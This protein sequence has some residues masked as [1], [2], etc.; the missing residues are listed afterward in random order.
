MPADSANVATDIRCDSRPIRASPLPIA[1]IA[2]TSGS[3]VAPSRPEDQNRMI[4]AARKPISSGGTPP[5]AAARIGEG[6]DR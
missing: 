1:A 6:I 4:S 2:L 5:L 3:T